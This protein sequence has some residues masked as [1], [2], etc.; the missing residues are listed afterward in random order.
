MP[1]ARL[2]GR[3]EGTWGGTGIPP[4]HP[5]GAVP[6]ALL[7]TDQDDVTGS[8]PDGEPRASVALPRIPP[9]SSTLQMWILEVGEDQYFARETQPGFGP[10]SVQ[11][12]VI[13]CRP[14]L[15]F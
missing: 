8:G 5:L 14:M 1:P 7:T 2:G 9:I 15:L 6:R 11:E 12:F 3:G 13:S 4:K 10:S